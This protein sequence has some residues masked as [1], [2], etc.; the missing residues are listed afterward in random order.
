MVV[1]NAPRNVTTEAASR[2][3]REALEIVRRRHYQAP[4]GRSVQLGD[5]IKAAKRGTVAYPPDAEIFWTPGPARAAR[6]EVQNESTI[7]AA[8]RLLA[9]GF[10]PVAR[11][12]R[13]VIDE[14]PGAHAAIDFAI[15]D[16]TVHREIIAPFERAFAAAGD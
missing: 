14:F 15:L 2:M 7:T 16:R 1:A 13:E 8:E 9:D 5:D 4:S 6:I 11:I 3:G 10:T 12:F